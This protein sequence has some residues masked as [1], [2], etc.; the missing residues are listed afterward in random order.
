MRGSVTSGEWLLPPD[1]W[2]PSRDTPG[3]ERAGWPRDGGCAGSPGAGLWCCLGSEGSRVQAA[4]FSPRQ[5]LFLSRDISSLARLR[6]R[7][8][9]PDKMGL[10]APQMRQ[11]LGP[12]KGRAGR[13]AELSRVCLPSAS[14]ATSSSS[15][16]V[17]GGCPV[18]SW[19]VLGVLEG[20]FFKF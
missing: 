20:F 1:S 16:G 18:A 5:A 15:D 3:G 17:P 13:R 4:C 9:G 19:S 12:R 14:L 7:V 2:I 10:W 8:P 11:R 6:A